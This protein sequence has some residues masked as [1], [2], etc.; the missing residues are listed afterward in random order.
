MSIC[1]FDHPSV[2]LRF[3]VASVCFALVW[4]P[5]ALQLIRFFFFSRSF[6]AGDIRLLFK[7]SE[8]L[9]RGCRTP[10]KIMTCFPTGKLQGLAHGV[11]FVMK[12]GFRLFIAKGDLINTMARPLFLLGST[13]IARRVRGLTN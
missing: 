3:V 13:P 7:G 1:T 12:I 2:Q 4:L 10:P 11:I 6:G 9:E 5:I 8:S